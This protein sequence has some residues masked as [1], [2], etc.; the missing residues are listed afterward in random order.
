MAGARE[1]DVERL[2]DV[3]T[4]ADRKVVSTLRK[5]IAGVIPEAVESVLWGGLSYH[6]PWVGG[7]VK[8]AVCQVNVKGGGVRLEFIHGVRLR[9]PQGLLRGD[10]LSK[11]FIPIGSPAEAE[12]PEIAALIREAS[13]LDPT[14]WT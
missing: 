6:R 3:L 10:R 8:G 4:P 13:Q 7:R 9:D 1:P 5:V 14:Q 2:L 12:R 11:R